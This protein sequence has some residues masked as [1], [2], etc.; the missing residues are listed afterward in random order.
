M[1]KCKSACPGG[2]ES[3]FTIFRY[4]NSLYDWA[5][6]PDKKRMQDLSEEEQKERKLERD[7][8][9]EL[10]RMRAMDDW[11]DGK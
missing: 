7:N 3:H 6:D 4:G 9:E 11:K 10:S 8:P 5:S 2:I 1:R